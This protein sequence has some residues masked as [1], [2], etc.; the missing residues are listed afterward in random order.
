MNEQLPTTIPDK[1]VSSTPTF[2]ELYNGIA[3]EP[4]PEEVLKKLNLKIDEN[5]IEI[6]PDGIIFLPEI[7]YRRT[8]NNAFGIGG[9]SILVKDMQVEEI[10]GKKTISLFKRSI[11]CI[12]TLSF[13][14]NWR[15]SLL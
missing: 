9:W 3:K 10:D 14:S 8:L 5:D 4:F 12:R 15:T 1:V 2:A 13:R 7:K 6:R 11:I